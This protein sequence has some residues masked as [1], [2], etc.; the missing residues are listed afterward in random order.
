MYREIRDF[1]KKHL[2]RVRTGSD[3]WKQLSEAERLWAENRLP[4]DHPVL[5]MLPTVFETFTVSGSADPLDL[6]WLRTVERLQTL[7]LGAFAGRVLA[8]P[9]GWSHGR[10]GGPS[11][12]RRP[13]GPR[14]ACFPNGRRLPRR[15][16]HRRLRS[17]IRTS[18]FKRYLAEIGEALEQGAVDQARQLVGAAMRPA[19]RRK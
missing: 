9:M 3:L 16:L 10:P 6:S 11:A 13:P 18:L 1:S 12:R 5:V 15:L 14:D 8:G 19:T 7:K 4:K 17:P 2:R